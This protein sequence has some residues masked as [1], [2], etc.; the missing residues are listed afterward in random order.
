MTN[1]APKPRLAVVLTA[2][3]VLVAGVV[4]WALYN[5][6][7]STVP[8]PGAGAPLATV[9][10]AKPPAKT[11]DRPLW[12]ELTRAQQA[13]LKPLQ[14]EWD[15]LE[16]MRKRRWLEMSQ[17]FASMTPAE[18]A[19]VHERMRQWMRLTPAQRE[20]A[21]E[22]YSKTR[23]LAPG[24]K[25][26]SWESYKQLSEE[27][28]QRLARS[29]GSRPQGAPAMPHTPMI[30][31]PVSCPPGA[32]RRGTACIV[33]PA[34]VPATASGP[35]PAAAPAAPGAVPQAPAAAPAP[36]PAPASVASPAPASPSP[37]AQSA[38]N[39]SN[40]LNVPV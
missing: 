2:A 21:R 23:K 24:E 30:A 14:P 5:R 6:S 25:A 33:P 28:R 40:A 15:S 12:R 20:L 38:P 31:A 39:A 37:A 18:Q 22:N 17:R 3:A 34:G 35:A 16:G 27:E 29:G 4:T 26:A 7:A 10:G 1:S 32:M 36:A 13:A 9:A 11:L 8:A 19:R